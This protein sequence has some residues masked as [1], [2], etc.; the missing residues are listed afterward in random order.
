[1]RPCKNCSKADRRCRVGEG[2]SKCVDCVRLGE[3][4]DLAPM[5]HNRWRRLERER[6]RLRVELREA[7][8][9]LLRLEQQVESVEDK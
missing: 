5:D 2:S 8:T 7:R 9:R 4:C 6:K 1:M 3:V